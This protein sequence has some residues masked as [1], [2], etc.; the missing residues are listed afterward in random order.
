MLVQSLYQHFRLLIGLGVYLTPYFL[1][2]G[3]GT[4]LRSHKVPGAYSFAVPPY[5]FI[6]LL[7]ASQIASMTLRGTTQSPTA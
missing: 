1:G 4:E 2:F 3:L 6:A 7:W 5:V